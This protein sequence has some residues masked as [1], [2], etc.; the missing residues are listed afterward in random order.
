M[1]RV[2][3]LS[4]HGLSTSYRIHEKA[5]VHTETNSSLMEMKL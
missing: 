5:I 1:V 2:S 3:L 4:V